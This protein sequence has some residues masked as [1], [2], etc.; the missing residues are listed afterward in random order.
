M[1][2]FDYIFYRIH[3]VFIKLPRATYTA[4][5]QSLCA[6][7]TLQW[8]NIITFYLAFCYFD[9][10][11]QKLSKLWVVLSLTLIILLN[12]LRYW[13]KHNIASLTQKWKDEQRNQRINRGIF[14]LFYVVFSIAMV[15]FAA[16]YVGRYF[17]HEL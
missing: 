4:D 2:F 16:D 17:R 8:F 1:V 9:N 3:N 14:V 10:S 7:S 12:Y 6:V 13:G 11:E 5:I 15:V